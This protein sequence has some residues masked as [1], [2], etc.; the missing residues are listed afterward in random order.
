MSYEADFINRFQPLIEEYKLNYKV[1][2]EEELA[3]FG[4]NFALVFL[5]HFD[6]V[7]L[8]YVSRDKDNSLVSYDVWSYFLH[9]FDDKDRENLPKYDSVR[10]RVDVS[11][12][13][14][15]R[16]LPRHWSRVLRGDDKWLEDYKQYELAGVPRNVIG[17]LKDG[18]SLYI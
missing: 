2:S 16:G 18:L 12:L 9:V 17:D 4:S 10:G 1:I 6:E 8:N 3:L 14:L 7:S 11:F 15:A 5:I 13:I